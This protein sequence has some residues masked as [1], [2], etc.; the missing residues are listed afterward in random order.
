MR[1]Q[2]G[3]WI[4]LVCL[5]GRELKGQ[6]DS[7]GTGLY[8]EDSTLILVRTLK[9]GLAPK[10]VVY[11]GQEL[12][13]AQNM[14]YRHTVSVFNRAFEKVATIKDGVYLDKHG[15]E[16]YGSFNRGA[17]VEA[18]FTHDGNYAWISNYCMF[19]DSLIHP[20]CD[21]CFSRTKYDPGFVYR[22]NTKTFEIEK[23]IEVGSVP[24]YIKA[25]S[26]NKYVL[27]SN[28]TSGDLSIIDVN[29]N[30]ELKSI[31]LGRFPRGIA[32]DSKDKFAYVAL[33]G[34]T[35][36]AR[37]DLEDFSVQWITGVGNRPRHL[38]ISPDDKYLY[39]SINHDRKVVK[40]DL[41]KDATVATCYTGSHPRSME[42][43]ANGQFLYVVNYYSNKLSK[44]DCQSFKL[45]EEARTNSK[46]IGITVDKQNGNVWVACY[47]GNIQVYRDKDFKQVSDMFYV[48]NPDKDEVGFGSL[49]ANIEKAELEII[50]HDPKLKPEPEKPKRKPRPEKPKA[51]KPK[52]KKSTP[53][54]TS[55]PPKP[56]PTPVA[57]KMKYHIIV[58]SFG[59]RSNAERLKQS[60]TRKGF[61]TTILKK[62]NGLNVVSIFQSNSLEEANTK[63]KGV[64]ANTLKDAW[65]Y[66]NPNM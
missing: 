47:V 41:A 6:N 12:F 28:W 31:Y 19:G 35:K 42:L 56:K 53:K 17:P 60:Y 2:A 13:F 25:T 20:G 37:I 39:A 14:M 15:Y 54:K 64:K 22:I 23:V 1:F 5:C 9:G 66:E 10:S 50:D 34:S 57:S 16:N 40:I 4:L 24:K 32:I 29:S 36:V 51:N 21:K 58:G 26:D 8:H 3:I 52:K 61:K 49:L 43:S 48:Q 62:S 63:L 30:E 18:T 55:S 38:C 45:V 7:T 33:M 46:P 11:N 59:V 27:V 65:V 44:I